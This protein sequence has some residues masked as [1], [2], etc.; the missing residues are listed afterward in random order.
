MYKLTEKEILE[1]ARDRRRGMGIS[2]LCIKYGISPSTFYRYLRERGITYRYSKIR[3]LTG[4]NFYS[5][6]AGDGC[7][8]VC[9]VSCGE[10]GEEV[11]CGEVKNGG[12]VKVGGEAVCEVSCG[13]V[14]GKTESVCEAGVSELNVKKY[15]KDGGFDTKKLNHGESDAVKYC[16]GALEKIIDGGLS[17][18]QKLER[19]RTVSE[20]LTDRICA[21]AGD[22]NQYTMVIS[23]DKAGI[24]KASAVCPEYTKKVDIKALKDM[25]STVR[26][27]TDCVR[28]LYGIPSFGESTRL[29]L[30]GKGINSD[31]TAN[32]AALTVKF[33]DGV[34]Y[35]E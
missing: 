34:D 30:A 21:A 31:G 2:E 26:V 19:L 32:D 28:T 11:S 1:A 18:G 10:V 3:H 7:E 20:I 14:G 24:K 27:L 8:A 17:S 15:L 25:A 16:E 22:E 13:E 35:A 9:E 23:S 12:R 5:G 6:E 33:T 29:Y 4:E